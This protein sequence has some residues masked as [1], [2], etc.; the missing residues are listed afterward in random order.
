MDPFSLEDPL[1]MDPLA[2]DL[3]DRDLMLADPAVEDSFRSDRL[4]VD[5]DLAHLGHLGE[6]EDLGNLKAGTF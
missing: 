6:P 1:R 2:L 4:K 3:L 5:L